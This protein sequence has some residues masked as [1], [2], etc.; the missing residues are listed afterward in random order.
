[1]V[2][3]VAVSLAA[4]IATSAGCRTTN[5]ASTGRAG[6]TNAPRAARRLPP[7][8]HLPE[9]ARPLL[10]TRMAHH[11]DDMEELVLSVILLEREVVATAA[12]A[13]ASEPGLARPLPRDTTSLNA[14]LPERFFVHQEELK[15]GA[16][17][18]A[19]DAR[20]GD[21]ETLA[22]TFGQLVSTCVR[23]HSAY[24]YAEPAATGQGSEE[25]LPA[26]APGRP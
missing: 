24:L 14:M 15:R 17:Q 11:A 5:V 1:V 2:Q 8:R 7:P 19:G 22:A 3:V 26:P 21:D 18:L 6:E 9:L 16:R 20:A 13:I 4:M 23:C 12:A 25:V 10:A